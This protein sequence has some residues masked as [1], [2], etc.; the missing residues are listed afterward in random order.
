VLNQ[1]AQEAHPLGIELHLCCEKEI[2]ADQPAKASI[3]AAA[4]VSGE[5][6]MAL[7]G[8]RVSRAAD[9]GQRRAMGCQ[10]S[11]SLDVGDYRRHPCFHDCLFCY[12]SPARDRSGKAIP[13][14]ADRRRIP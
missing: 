8:G 7:Y 9:P 1:L 4:C 12:A 3:G 11:R 2:L 5:R 6:L 10:C 13:A 14:A